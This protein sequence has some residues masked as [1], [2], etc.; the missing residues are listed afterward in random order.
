MFVPTCPLTVDVPLKVNVPSLSVA[1]VIGAF[2]FALSAKT[3]VPSPV[4]FKLSAFIDE[5][6]VTVF[7]SAP[8]F[9]CANFTPAVPI[10][11]VATESPKKVKTPCEPFEVVIVEVILEPSVNSKVEL[12]DTPLFKKVFVA[13]TSPFIVVVE[14]LPLPPLSPIFKVF[15]ELPKLPIF[16]ITF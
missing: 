5:L 10:V 13:N 8:A 11:P 6:K 7:K 3:T 14:Y 2:I 9:I 1:V 16:P 4:I 15:I 12:I